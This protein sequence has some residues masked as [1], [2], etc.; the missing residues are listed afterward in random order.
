MFD[1]LLNRVVLQILIS[2]GNKNLKQLEENVKRGKSLNEETLF[3]VLQDSKDTV[4]GRKY[5]FEDIK[6]VEDYKKSVPLSAFE[7]YAD[8][9]D[10]MKDDGE[11]GLLTNTPIVFYAMSSGSCGRPK[12]F[13]V[14]QEEID[15]YATYAATRLFACTEAYHKKKY[16]KGFPRGRGLNT[17]VVKST[18]TKQGIRKG[19]ISCAAVES[20]KQFLKYFL[21]S[22]EEVLFPTEECDMKYLQIRYA[23]MDPD[24]VFMVGNFM[25]YLVEL[26]NYAKMNWELLC[27]DIEQGCIDPSIQLGPETR[28]A[29][30]AKL[31]PDPKRAARL[32]AIAQQGFVN[33]IIPKIWPRMSW[34]GAVGSNN[35]SPYTTKMRALA[36]ED[37]FIDFMQY[38]ASES[39]LGC[40]RQSEEQAFVLI[41]DSCYY[42]FIPIDAPEGTTETLDVSELE[43]GKEYEVI[44]TNKA[45]LYRYRMNDVLRVMGYYHEMPMV[46]CAYRKSE[47]IRLTCEKTTEDM[48]NWMI[49]SF[50]EDTGVSLSNFAIYGDTNA[51]PP[52]YVLLLEP[53]QPVPNE[54]IPEYEKL[55]EEKLEYVNMIYADYI[56][57]NTLAPLKLYISKKGSHAEY[58]RFKLKGGGLEHQTKPVRVLDTQD[59]REFFLARV[60]NP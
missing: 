47:M 42:E 11:T 46:Q 36:G 10:R 15:C 52:R 44:I 59:K 19:W 2:R 23:L 28:K 24:M 13:P 30:E 26:I 49:E 18:L 6:S 41:P 20:Q 7:D 38:G 17:M 54:K 1:K 9:I 50:C 12:D 25:V 57:S 21:T 29:L 39:L 5:H 60:E 27:R 32:R 31:R 53:E 56:E 58:T 22:P 34:I 48:V 37:V 45:G 16:G 55:L 3:R 8:D 43:V 35:F 14:T 40:T 33:P 4:Y 51:T